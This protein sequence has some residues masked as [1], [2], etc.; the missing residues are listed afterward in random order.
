MKERATP[1]WLD[2]LWLLFL[3]GLALIPP[4]GELHK[5]LILLI[6]GIF[7][8]LENRFVL[9]TGKAGPPLAVIIKIVLA[10]VLINHTGEGAAINSDYYPIYYLPVMTAAMYYGPVGTLLW[11]LAASVAYSSYLYQASQH[12]TIT[13]D[14]ISELAMRL[15]FFFFV[16][17]TVNRF[18]MQYR[19]QV[20][21]FQELSENLAEANRSLKLAQEEARRAERLAALGQ[22]SAGLAHEIRNP[23]GVIKGSAEIL[24][25]KLEGADPLAKELGGYIYTEVNRVSALVSRFLD[26][27]R[28]SQLALAPTDLADLVE[29]CVTTVSDQG[30]CKAVKVHRDFAQGL[31]QVMLDQDLCEQV[32]TNLLMNACEAMGEQGGELKIRVQRTA[33]KNGVMAEIEDSGPGVPPEMKEQIFNPFVTTKKTGVGLG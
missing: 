28:P 32:F 24:T 25:Q 30:A 18:V 5:Q 21:R 20:R 8:L 7:Q 14:S 13:A 10:T 19:L 15:L 6:I 23:L 29:R 4:I 1:R 22:L 33:E 2:V 31:P 3:V 27:A 16:A 26:F 9:L 12:F 11:T 17:M